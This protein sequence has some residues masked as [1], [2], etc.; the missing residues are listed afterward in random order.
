[1]I[2]ALPAH[3]KLNLELRVLG[4]RPD[5]HHEVET[6]LQAIDLHDLLE[7]EVAATSSLEVIGRP[8]PADSR[9]LVLAALAAL[10]EAAGR[11]LPVRLRLVKRIP[12]GAGLGG[13]SSDA[14]AALRAIA[15][16]H[17]VKADLAALAAGIGADVPFFLS[18]GTARGRGRGERLEPLPFHPG[19]FALAWPGLELS[20]EDVY[21]AWDRVG[22]D[23]PNQLRRAACRAAPELAVFAAELDDGWQMTG[24]GSAFFKAFPDSRAAASATVGLS[25]W[26]AVCRAVPAW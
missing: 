12:G 11:P 14:A 25:S 13:G 26:S 2:L 3:A 18:G 23:G 10:E 7:V 24:S 5:G 21:R 9:N 16:L 6:V 22:G 19:W 17:S 20:T 15:R 1:L 8:A 4:T